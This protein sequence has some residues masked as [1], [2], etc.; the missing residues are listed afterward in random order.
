MAAPDNQDHDGLNSGGREP[1][2]GW[3]VGV[4][5]VLL[6]LMMLTAAFALGVYLAERNL[7]G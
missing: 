2:P 6:V 3:L 4:G 1:R 7:L 5:V